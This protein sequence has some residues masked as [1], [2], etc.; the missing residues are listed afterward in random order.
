MSGIFARSR[1]TPLLIYAI[2]F[3]HGVEEQPPEQRESMGGKSLSSRSGIE[4][5][6]GNIS[7]EKEDAASRNM[8]NCHFKSLFCKTR[9]QCSKD[10]SNPFIQMQLLQV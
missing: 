5:N 4:S 1:I 3:D 7:E 10:S 9:F 2:F 8:D 6:S